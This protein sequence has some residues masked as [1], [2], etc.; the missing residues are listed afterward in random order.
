MQRGRFLRQQ[1]IY[2]ETAMQLARF[3][4]LSRGGLGFILS[5]SI[6][7]GASIS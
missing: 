3:V 2:V 1:L 4:N 7:T 6:Q 5:V